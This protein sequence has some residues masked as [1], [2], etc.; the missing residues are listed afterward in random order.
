MAFAYRFFSFKVRNVHFQRKETKKW[1][2][3]NVWKRDWEQERERETNEEILAFFISARTIEIQPGTIVIP[4][5]G[6]VFKG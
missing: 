4:I 2:A 6:M 5:Y 1:K 3:E